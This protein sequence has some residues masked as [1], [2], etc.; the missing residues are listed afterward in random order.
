MVSQLA[1]NVFKVPIVLTRILDPAREEIYQQLDLNII[2][3]TK[4][5]A[6]TFLENLQQQL[7]N[8]SK[9]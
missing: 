4:I 5:A 2:S 8:S 9:L 1:K 6:T 7:V 3:T